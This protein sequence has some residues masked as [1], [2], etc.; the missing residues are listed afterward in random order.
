MK[1][2]SHI[3]H[4]LGDP[5]MRGVVGALAPQLLTMFPANGG[6]GVCEEVKARNGL[7]SGSRPGCVST[8]SAVPTVQPSVPKRPVKSEP[9]VKVES[10]SEKSKP[11][12]VAF[13]PE[14]NPAPEIIVPLVSPTL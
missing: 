5:S 3:Q 12:K 8:G 14:P 10:K 11:A 6:G 1:S 9:A 7:P 13:T 4:V 2:L